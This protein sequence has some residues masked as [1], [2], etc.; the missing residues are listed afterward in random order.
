MDHQ[1]LVDS[2]ER[3]IKLYYFGFENNEYHNE[4]LIFIPQQQLNHTV[5]QAKSYLARYYPQLSDKFDEFSAYLITLLVQDSRNALAIDIYSMTEF[6]SIEDFLVSLKTILKTIENLVP[7]EVADSYQSDTYYELVG[8]AQSAQVESTFLEYSADYQEAVE[9]YYQSLKKPTN[10]FSFIL[11]II[12]AVTGVFLLWASIAKGVPI[13]SVMT[14]VFGVFI[15]LIP[16]WFAYLEY[17]K[18]RK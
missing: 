11:M 17:K 5:Q 6:F 15:A 13:A 14:S 18:L 3:L 1:I 7:T 4:D 16:L 8:N 12:F 10:W 9:Q 2:E